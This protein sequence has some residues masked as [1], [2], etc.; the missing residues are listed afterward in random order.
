MAAQDASFVAHP[1][2][3]GHEGTVI[4]KTLVVVA[5][6]L[7]P[8]A[9]SDDDSA[10]SA[11]SS[12][13]VTPRSTPA[14]L[15]ATVVHPAKLRLSWSASIDSGTGVAGYKVYRDGVRI[16]STVETSYQDDDVKPGQR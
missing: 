2:S 15:V 1:A 3:N 5:F 8:G 6:A 7:G 4:R 12:A 14:E 10:G 16:A 9:C 11:A 13:D